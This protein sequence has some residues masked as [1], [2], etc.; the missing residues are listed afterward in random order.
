[1]KKIKKV[2]RWFWFW[3]L[4]LLVLL[5]YFKKIQKAQEEEIIS[6]KAKI[7]PMEFSIEKK[8]IILKWSIHLNLQ[9]EIIT[10]KKNMR[11]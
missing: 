2:R 10:T 11:V 9:G 5:V 7:V 4:F 8:A 3:F 6:L 1:M